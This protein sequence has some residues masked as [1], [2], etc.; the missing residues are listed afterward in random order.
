MG[1]HDVA[2]YLVG[3]GAVLPAKAD[4]MACNLKM[5]LGNGKASLSL[6][7]VLGDPACEYMYVGII[8]EGMDPCSPYVQPALSEQQQKTRLQEMQ[9]ARAAF[10]LEAQR[11]K[12]LAVNRANNMD[13]L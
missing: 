2:L 13:V 11:L 8:L 10:L 9:A 4:D 5:N 6:G 12:E 3:Q 7:L 1:N